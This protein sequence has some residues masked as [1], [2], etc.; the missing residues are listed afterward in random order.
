MNFL[1]PAA[2]FLGSMAVPIVVLYLRRP[3]RRPLEFSSLLFWQRVLEREPHRK[4]LGRLRNPLSL[5][6]QLVIMLLLLLALAR[7]QEVSSRGH[8]S[9]V[10]VLDMRAR[11]Q[12]P[13][14]FDEALLAA[15]DV[16]SRLGPHDEVAILAVEGAPRI[17]SSFSSDGKELRR[18]LSSLE[19][20]DAGGNLDEAMVLA[21]RLLDAK[22]GEKRLIVIGD[23]K[24][25]APENAEQ[26]TV[27]KSTDNLAVLALAQRPLPASPQS[28]ELM[29]RLGNFS[30]GAN[31]AELELS[32]DGKPF[33]LQRFPLG[34]GEQRDFSAIIPKEM[35]ASGTGFLIARLTSK[36]ALNFDN[37]ARAVLPTGQQLR[38][39]LVG[40]DDPF[41]E[42][43]LKADPSIAVEILRPESWRSTLGA[44]FDVVIFDNWLPAD[45]ASEK[46][47][48]EP[49]FF[50]GRT[51]FNLAGEQISPDFLEAS[52]SDSPLL[53]NVEFRDIRLTKAEKLTVPADR[54]WRAS[55]PMRS[56]G[57]PMVM[58]LEDPQG[59]R[60]VAVAFAVADSNFPLRVGF[61]LFVSNVI[62]WLAERRSRSEALV[63][64]GETFFPR[65]GEEIRKNPLPQ[66]QAAG[67]TE[68]ATYSPTPF[69]VR[70]NGFYEVRGS[71]GT[72]WLAVNTSDAAE[73]DVRAAENENKALS[74]TGNWG[75]WQAW[76]WLAL[77]ALVLLVVEWCLH[78]RRVT[79]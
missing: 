62:H 78:L 7:P 14:I 61:P 17:V 48:S 26:I 11:M 47:G 19:P 37:S 21:G 9:T 31:T 2:F 79:E 69:T 16:V 70:K 58:A 38:V 45:L 59:A 53:W 74:F 44:G 20:S 12:A 36:D 46:L 13:G 52:E 75:A 49:S 32:L 6:F 56:A 41:L 24:A 68:P 27:G 3:S 5:I 18:K 33:D 30:R 29:V 65:A 42:N 15:Q 72:R 64:A 67:A 23:R 77:A 57:E 60:M 51:P 66:L 71:E 4:F 76:R 54:R 22:P 40:E 63:K 35:L 8:R 10:L 1:F 73:S 55:I 34:P 43:A 39:L 28:A 50:F 25:A